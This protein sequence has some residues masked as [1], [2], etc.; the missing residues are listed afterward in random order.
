[1]LLSRNPIQIHAYVDLERP[2]EAKWTNSEVIETHINAG[3]T[4]LY[5]IDPTFN[6]MLWDDDGG[7]GLG[8]RIHPSYQSEGLVI[9]GSFSRYT[10]GITALYNWSCEME[11][12]AMRISGN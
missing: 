3:D 10:E 2:V 4:Y 7:N 9:V 8:S 5:L 1:M 6:I 12:S 11:S